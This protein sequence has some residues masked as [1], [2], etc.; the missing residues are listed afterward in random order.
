[1]ANVSFME[2]ENQMIIDAT[3][4][5]IGMELFDQWNDS[6]LDEGI[7][8]ADWKIAQMSNS[9]YLKGRFNQHWE[10]TPEDEYYLEWDEEA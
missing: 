6:N 8:Y 2:N 1:M 3:I 5:E 10:L 4:Q 9:N 7:L